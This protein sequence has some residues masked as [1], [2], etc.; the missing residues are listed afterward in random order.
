MPRRNKND[1]DGGGGQ[2]TEVPGTFIIEWYGWK[3]NTLIT[4]TG[5]RGWAIFTDLQPFANPPYQVVP[6]ATYPNFRY[7][8][9]QVY[10]TF[11]TN[12]PDSIVKITCSDFNNIGPNKGGTFYDRIEHMNWHFYKPLDPNTALGESIPGPFTRFYFYGPNTN[13]K[14]YKLLKSGGSWNV[15]STVYSTVVQTTVF[16][17]GGIIPNQDLTDV[18]NAM[19]SEFDVSTDGGTLLM[20]GFANANDDFV[21]KFSGQDSMQTM[22][23]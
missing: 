3:D 21:L 22:T 18:G 17:Y 14:I 13:N 8:N 2:P 12:A 5:V 9:E 11:E 4:G 15:G 7:D 6:P 23:I 19:D 10:E 16:S 20:T 1:G